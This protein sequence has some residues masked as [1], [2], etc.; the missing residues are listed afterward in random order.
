LAAPKVCS[1]RLFH[2]YGLARFAC[3][4]E[5]VKKRKKGVKADIER[6][7]KID[8]V[9]SLLARTKNISQ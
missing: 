3:C 2:V 7:W 4:P 8:P 9:Y 6:R 1:T 5:I